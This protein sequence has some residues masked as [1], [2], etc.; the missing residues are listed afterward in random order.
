MSQSEYK[1]WQAQHLEMLRKF[2]EYKQLL[3]KGNK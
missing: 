3:L 2:K 1:L